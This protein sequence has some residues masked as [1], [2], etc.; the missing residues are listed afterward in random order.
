MKKIPSFRVISN[1]SVVLYLSYPDDSATYGTRG[2]TDHVCVREEER[3]HPDH[4]ESEV[5]TPTD[6]DSIVK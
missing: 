6:C 2:L 3:E 4:E 1:L 5:A